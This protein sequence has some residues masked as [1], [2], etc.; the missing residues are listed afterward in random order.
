MGDADRVVG[1]GGDHKIDI[2]AKAEALGAAAAAPIKANGDEGRVLDLD[3]AALGGGFEAEFAQII[4]LEDTGEQAD[5]G[6]SPDRAAAI[7]P[8]AVTLDQ[9]R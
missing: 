5:H 6:F 7:E 9:E 2:G 8:S 3:F 1:S 4:A